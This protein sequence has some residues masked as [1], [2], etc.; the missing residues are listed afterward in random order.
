ML[1]NRA[2]EAVCLRY[3]NKRGVITFDMFV[4]I[5]VR[6]ILTFGEYVSGLPGEGGG[7]F[8]R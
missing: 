6:V 4:Q 7:S 5:N 8:E 2:L 3:Y 1:S